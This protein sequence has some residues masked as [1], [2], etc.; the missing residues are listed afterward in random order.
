MRMTRFSRPTPPPGLGA[1]LCAPVGCQYFGRPY[2]ARPYFGR[3]YFARPYFARPYFAR[4]CTTL[5]A[6]TG[7]VASPGPGRPPGVLALEVEAAE[8][9]PLLRFRARV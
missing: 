6:S 1:F 7:L 4:R 5:R 9:P 3:P 8:A 2:F